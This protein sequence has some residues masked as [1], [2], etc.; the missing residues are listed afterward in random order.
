MG[1]IDELQGIQELASVW[2][3]IRF[4]NPQVKTVS[5]KY[6]ITSCHLN[7]VVQKYSKTAPS[8]REWRRVKNLQIRKIPRLNSVVYN[9]VSLE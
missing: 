9:V 6:K 1:T 5:Y 7:S 3:A 2:N 8:K 4:K